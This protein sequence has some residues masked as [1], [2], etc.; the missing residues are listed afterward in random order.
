M[1]S[2][3]RAFTNLIKN[4]RIYTFTPF[5]ATMLQK[6]FAG[7]EQGKVMRYSAHYER[8]IEMNALWN[9]YNRFVFKNEG[10]ENGAEEGEHV[11]IGNEDIESVLNTIRKKYDFLAQMNGLPVSATEFY[12][13]IV[14]PAY[15]LKRSQANEKQQSLENV[16]TKQEDYDL[17]VAD[18]CDAA[19]SYCAGNP[20]TNI[21][22]SKVTITRYLK[23]LAE[24]GF[25]LYENKD[26]SRT[27]G[28]PKIVVP[29]VTE[30]DL[31][32]ASGSET[33]SQTVSN[34]ES[35]KYSS[36]ELEFKPL[37]LLTNSLSVTDIEKTILKL[38]GYT[39]E[40]PTETVN[41]TVSETLTET[42][43][44]TVNE[45]PLI[46]RFFKS[47]NIILDTCETVSETPNSN[48]VLDT[49]PPD[50]NDN[51]TTPQEPSK[52]NSNP[53]DPTKPDN[54]PAA[55]KS[56]INPH[57]DTQAQSNQQVSSPIPAGSVLEPTTQN[58]K[59]NMVML[60]KTMEKEASEPPQE[61]EK[62]L[63]KEEIIQRVYLAVKLAERDSE[64][65]WSDPDLGEPNKKLYPALQGLTTYLI[66]EALKAL[67][68][69]GY[70]M[71]VKP[72]YWHA[73]KDLHL[74]DILVYD[75][76]DMPVYCPNCMKPTTRLYWYDAG[77]LCVDCLN[78]RQHQNE[79]LYS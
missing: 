35:I 44:E 16:N 39:T 14:L 10:L 51:A 9:Y 21:K 74:V 73:T 38:S 79:E 68:K 48:N 77:W 55:T 69:E 60:T 64:A 45:T 3:L 11:L 1:K 52:P 61:R 34:M 26:K 20:S 37:N 78:A 18:L 31:W 71:Q 2:E 28:K 13:E 4:K 50:Q 32:Q 54:A 65:F 27:A 15:K 70:I 42:P 58:Q 46:A 63:S 19:K 29:Q 66:Q 33:V 59:Q 62:S 24:R 47:L 5:D 57:L 7:A 41:E 53:T 75:N 56:S 17:T 22:S 23:I 6:I 36:I 30:E 8:H 76:P 12:V 40:T 67:Q 49:Q 43:T 25:I 72:G